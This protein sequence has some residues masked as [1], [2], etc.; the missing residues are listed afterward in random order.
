MWS[1]NLFYRFGNKCYQYKIPVI[2]LLCKFAIRLFFN[3][4][5]DCGTKIGKGTSFGYGGIAVVVHKRAV[6]GNNVK[7][8][9]CVTIGGRSKKI[10]VPVIGNNV[11]IAT[12]AK[13]LGDV[14]IGNNV[15]IGANAVVIISVPDNSVV[16]GIQA[17]V[18]K[19]N[20][21]YS[22]YV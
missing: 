3:S 9:Q 1:I 18:I 11:Y 14:V 15:I 12:G 19:N 16:A 4:A 20:I 5:V 2:P 13:I 8:G 22:D 7:I 10:N 6:I 17:K 21:Q